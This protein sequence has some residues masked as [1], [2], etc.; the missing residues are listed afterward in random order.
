MPSMHVGARVTGGKR[1]DKFLISAASG[2]DLRLRA[3]E[4]L[5]KF[6]A[7]FPMSSLRSQVP[8]RTGRLARSLKLVRRGT[9]IELQG[10]FYGA[11]K[12][13]RAKIEAVFSQL[14]RETARRI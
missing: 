8:N 3:I 10:E 11:F 2:E 12:P 14:A 5:E 9:T 13:S 7:L 6:V 1:L 4:W